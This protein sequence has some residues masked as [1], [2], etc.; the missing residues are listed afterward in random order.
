MLPGFARGA[1][2][3]FPHSHWPILPAYWYW[4]GCIVS[5]GF[6]DGFRFHGI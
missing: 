2:C 6:Y 3:R 5:P 4:A 1:N